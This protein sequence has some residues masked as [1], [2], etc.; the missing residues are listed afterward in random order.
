MVDA[1]PGAIDQLER[2]AKEGGGACYFTKEE[3]EVLKVVVVPAARFFIG[4]GR[5]GPPFLKV[6]GWM[7]AGM[8]FF[9]MVSDWWY[10]K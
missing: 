6:C 1:E 10:R 8:A 3:A 9:I 2:V 7:G 5:L 4:L